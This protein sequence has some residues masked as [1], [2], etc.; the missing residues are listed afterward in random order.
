VDHNEF[1]QY[2][3][4]KHGTA[5]QTLGNQWDWNIRLADQLGH[6]NGATAPTCQTCHFEYRASTRTTWC[7]RCAGA[8]CRSR[9][10]PTTWS[11]WFKERKDAWAATCSQCHAP[12]FAQTY[13]TM[14]DD[15]I[16]LGTGLVEQSRKV[17]QKLYDDKLLVGQKTNRTPCRPRR[18]TNPEAS[19]HCFCHQ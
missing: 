8:F 7:A 6:K 3:Y 2:M 1:E 16:K 13:L 17:M 10:L 5:Y 15:G 19:R 4:S 12:R 11:T 14:M 9:A 18:R